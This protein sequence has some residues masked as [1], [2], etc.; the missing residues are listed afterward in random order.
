[1]HAERYRTIGGVAET[2]GV[3]RWRLAYLIERGIVPDAS[4]R[5]PGRRLFSDEDVSRIRLAIAE[6]A[7]KETTV[8]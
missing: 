2:L 5:V 4:V 7:K 3:P 8:G 1:M 6:R